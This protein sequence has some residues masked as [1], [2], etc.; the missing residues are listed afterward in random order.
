MDDRITKTAG[1]LESEHKPRSAIEDQDKAKSRGKPGK[2]QDNQDAGLVIS[3]R[4]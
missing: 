3:H 1:V 2:T 4:S